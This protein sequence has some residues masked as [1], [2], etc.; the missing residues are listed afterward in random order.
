MKLDSKLARLL[1]ANYR[2][3]YR[4]ATNLA[5]SLSRLQNKFPLDEVSLKQ[6][7]EVEKDGVDAFRVRFSDLQDTVG[8]KL[9]KSIVAIQEERADTMLDVL[10]KMEKYRIIESFESWKTLREIRNIFSHDYPESE[11]E[12]A[13]ALNLAFVNAPELLKILHRIY[14]YMVD[15]L[16]LSPEPWTITDIED[17]HK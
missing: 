10:N 6:L 11:Q 12:R 1:L 7:T 14:Y 5:S 9:F 4:T 15:K 16:E 17:A 3:S 8:Q 13:E 2:E